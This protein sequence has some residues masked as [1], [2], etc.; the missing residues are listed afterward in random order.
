MSFVLTDLRLLDLVMGN[1]RQSETS[2]VATSLPR[3]LTFA[4]SSGLMNA[5]ATHAGK[6]PDVLMAGQRRK[7]EPMVAYRLAVG[8]RMIFPV[9]LTG[10]LIQTEDWGCLAVGARRM[11]C[12]VILIGTLIQ[13]EDWSTVKS[14]QISQK[15]FGQN[16]GSI[17]SNELMVL[18]RQITDGRCHSR[19]R[20]RERGGRRRRKGG[21]IRANTLIEEDSEST[22]TREGEI[23]SQ[24]ENFDLHS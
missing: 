8:G 13:A 10:T 7:V 20:E 2:M 3:I 24:S 17:H 9:S 1:E 4:S 19:E 18:M 16:K 22:R 6:S 11:G 23:S 12:P 14:V 5:R 21:V 15:L